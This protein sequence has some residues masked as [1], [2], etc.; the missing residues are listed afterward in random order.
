MAGELTILE[1]LVLGVVQGVTEWLP[2]SSSGHLVL[3]Q[4]LLG[5]QVDI[6]F[7]L[8]LHVATLA[9]ILGFY[10]G[11]VRSIL[12]ASW[13]TPAALRE[14]DGRRA[15][16]LGDPDRRLA[17]LVLVGSVPTAVVGFAL[18]DAAVAWF[19][20]LTAVGVGLAATG[21]WLA[22]TRLSP[23]PGAPGLGI[24]AALV[25]G[26]AQGVAVVPGI[27]R[28]GATIGAALLAGVARDE[29]VEFSFLL[30]VPAILGATVFQADAA[31]LGR[32][33]AQL[34]PVL[35]GSAVAALVGYVAL[36]LL[37]RIVER[38]AFHR[39]ALYCLPLGVAVLAVAL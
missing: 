23:L 29:A 16:L 10:R 14:A 35:A 5:I 15:A 1:A 27:S 39:F 22:L 25:V 31:A 11:R 12:R 30:S 26:L 38:G 17:V 20:S 9:V 19:S 13:R 2:V 3:A 32:A 8:V 6:F 21:V 33:S 7:D 24:A 18:E 36:A 34:G 4:Q 37:V 28:S